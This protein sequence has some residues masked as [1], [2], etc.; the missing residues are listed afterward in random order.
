MAI[1]RE[2]EVLSLKLRKISTDKLLFLHHRMLLGKDTRFIDVTPKC[3]QFE[4]L[5]FMKYINFIK[6]GKVRKKAA[7]GPH[8]S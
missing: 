5:M 3:S 7:M 4:I 6:L 1:C 8:F 2:F